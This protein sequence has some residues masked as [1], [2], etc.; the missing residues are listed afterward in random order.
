VE[1]QL[2]PVLFGKTLERLAVDLRVRGRRHGLKSL[3]HVASCAMRQQLR[4]AMPVQTEWAMTSSA[5]P[6][7]TAQSG[8][9]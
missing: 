8:R 3:S 6:P 5:I 7:W 2:L 9:R 1:L 4:F